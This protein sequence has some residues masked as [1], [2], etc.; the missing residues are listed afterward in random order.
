MRDMP[1]D[2]DKNPYI[3]AELRAI[4]VIYDV[5]IES[6]IRPYA[7]GAYIWWGAAGLALPPHENNKLRPNN[8][9]LYLIIS[10]ID[11]IN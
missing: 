8:A 5:R 10:P 11:L 9:F 3:S 7:R 2:G 4:N 1:P 6:T